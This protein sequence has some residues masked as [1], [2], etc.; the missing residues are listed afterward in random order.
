MINKILRVA[1]DLSLI[2]IG[3]FMVIMSF[4]L[5]ISYHDPNI[6]H[7]AMTPIYLLV[8]EIVIGAVLIVIGILNLI[9]SP[10]KNNLVLI[11]SMLILFY[12]INL[13][14]MKV[15]QTHYYWEFTD[16]ISLSV[17]PL[18]VLLLYS[19]DK[20]DM[21]VRLIKLKPLVLVIMMYLLV[22]GTFFNYSYF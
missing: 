13:N 7:F 19:Y 16:L 10:L 4:H 18:G 6:L 5:M 9:K 22:D 1:L 11:N 2:L 15:V 12:P 3:L 21:W 8:M 20:K 14:L 17:A